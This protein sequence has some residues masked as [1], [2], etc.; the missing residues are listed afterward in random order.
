MM[1]ALLRVVFNDCA[2]TPAISDLAKST[3]F[4]KEARTKNV[5]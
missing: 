2:G 4:D 3:V 5:E 1:E